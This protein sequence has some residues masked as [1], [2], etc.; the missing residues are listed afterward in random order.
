MAV[1]ASTVYWTNGG[2]GPNSGTVMRVGL[3]GG[4]PDV[5]ASNQDAPAGIAVDATAVYWTSL[6]S[7]DGSP[8]GEVIK[9]A[10]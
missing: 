1:D 9:I 3:S 8:D 10:K 4:A 7:N 2:S 5:V 6:G